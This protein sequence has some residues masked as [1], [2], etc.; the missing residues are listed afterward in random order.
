MSD[1]LVEAVKWCGSVGLTMLK[2]GD[3]VR[4]TQDIACDDDVHVG[5]VGVVV[6]RSATRHTY[7]WRVRFFHQ[8]KP[9]PWLVAEEEIEHVEGR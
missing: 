7:L 2:V 5:D 6:G 4:A 9:T 3:V 1:E 8:R